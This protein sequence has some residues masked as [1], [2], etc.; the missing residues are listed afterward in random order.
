MDKLAH[1]PGLS[2]CILTSGILL[3]VQA[4]PPDC[5]DFTNV[6]SLFFGQLSLAVDR[7][8]SNDQYFL[9]QSRRQ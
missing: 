2:V 7:S 3:D 1:Q 9:R 8:R 4:Y 5:D 6:S